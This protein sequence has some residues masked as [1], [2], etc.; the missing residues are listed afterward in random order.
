MTSE[1]ESTGAEVGGGKQRVRRFFNSEDPRSVSRRTSCLHTETMRDFDL[2][3]AVIKNAFSK[4]FSAL[5]PAQPPVAGQCPSPPGPTCT[6][7]G[8]RVLARTTRRPSMRRVEESTGMPW[9]CARMAETAVS[10]ISL[11]GWA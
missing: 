2:A 4:T 5:S 6:P 3:V 11:R 9:I 10:I 7:T 8:H 1:E